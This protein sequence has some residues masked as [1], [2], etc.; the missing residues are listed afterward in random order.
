M[1]V[2]VKKSIPHIIAI[3]IFMV[4][5]SIYFAPSLFQGKV[6]QQDD[7]QNTYGM[8]EELTQ[9]YQKEG[10]K[11]AWTGSA[12]SG[13]PAYNIFMYG[14]P[15]N[16]LSYLDKP[17]VG[18]DYM[19]ASMILVALICFYILMCVMGVKRWLAIA[20]SIAFAF[21][22]YNFIIVMVGHITKMYVIA[23]M[24][25]TVA[26]MIL[27]FC[28]NWLWGTILLCLGA[29]FSIMNS[30]LQISYY[31][32]LFSV[33]FF[34]GLSVQEFK[35][36]EYAPWVKITLCA[37]VAILI[38]V[39]PSL[40]NL[41]SNYE[42][43]KESMR[44]PSE[45]TL[46]NEEIGNKPSSGLDMDY[47][48]AWSL[49]KGELITLL[50]PGAYG[51]SSGETLDSDSHFYKTYK[52]M[53]G[54]VGKNFRAPTYWGD[55]PF[56][57]G[58]VYFGAVVCFL[59][60]LGIF[61]IQNPLKWWLLG[62][63]LFFI[64]LSLGENFIAF[65]RFIFHYLPLYNKFRVPSTALVI[66]NLIFPMV[67]FWGLKQIA[68]EKI[69]A[70]W[71][72]KSL[73]GSLIL[74]GGICLLLWVMPGTFLNFTSSRDEQFQIPQLIDALIAD[75]KAM[76]SSDALR[77]LV[78]ILLA[79]G[80]I[81]YFIQTSNKKNGWL[82]LGIGML[83]LVT[84]DLWGVDKRYLNDASFTKQKHT[85]AYKKTAAD[86]YILQDHSP[87][88]RVLNL[89]QSTFSEAHTSYFHKSIGGYHGA[90]LRRYQELIDHRLM[91]EIKTIVSAFQEATS[92]ED[93]RDVFRQTPT[94]DML[95]AKYIIYHADQPPLIN[96]YADGNAWF[97]DS[98]LF[99]A[100]ANS[101][102]E[103]LNRINPLITA[104]IDEKFAAQV[105]QP[106]EKPAESDSIQLIDYKPNI[107]EYKSNSSSPQIA[108]FSEVYY[109]HGWKAFI[110]GKPADHYRVN[111]ILRAMNVPAGNHSIEFRFEPDTYNLLNKIGSIASLVMLLGFIGA[112]V[113]SLLPLWKNR[114][115]E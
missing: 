110:D 50:I 49:G 28:K 79:G 33:L 54:R 91:N 75:R 62:I 52:S 98:V 106:T 99:V 55:Q 96:M 101:E 107:L 29:C 3:A 76:A 26:G 24:P 102:I 92:L 81:F 105:M 22:S 72:K 71:L 5:I 9:Y 73:I 64:F 48:F 36:K 15:P 74:T 93:L 68:D 100:N 115:T 78:F 66:P 41:Y 45:L 87:S 70:A 83:V 21:A 2:V 63:S 53:G 97:V 77:S 112:L 25:L 90:K 103:A 51:G 17:I 44:G 18:I 88:Y 46:S 43:S 108:V 37:I 114:K 86:E 16:Y 94:L 6:I 31:L 85:E 65:N 69:E 60:V 14:N 23:Y 47:A 38:S 19:G 104:A 8:G 7:M 12:F 109:P 27:L 39:L 80:L 58:P 11:S 1:N 59:F 34:I 113:Y 32:T 111:W 89:T 61:I 40:G 42:I 13:M 10:G 57:A 95:N 4:L 84:V 30:H 56:T 35:L 82:A 20:G 67:G